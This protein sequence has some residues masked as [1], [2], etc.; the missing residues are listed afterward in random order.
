MRYLLFLLTT[1]GLACR[2]AADGAAST[3]GRLEG[4]WSSGGQEVRFSAP[5]EARWCER[6][7]SLEVF[8][9]RNDTALGLALYARDTLRAEAYPVT[10]AAM[11]VPARP[12]ATVALRLALATELKGYESSGGQVQVTTGGSRRV[13]GSFAAMLRHSVGTDSL[14]VSGSFDRLAVLP[15]AASCGRALKPGPG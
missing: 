15:A 10:L 9:V 7:S 2:P 3:G 12:Q 5:A 11:F 6:D 13:S 4:R 1:G 14:R 8:A